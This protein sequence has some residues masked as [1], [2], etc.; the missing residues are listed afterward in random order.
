VNESER[1]ETWMAIV[2]IMGRM[3]EQL[4][5]SKI[6]LPRPLH[7]PSDE[8]AGYAYNP[9]CDCDVCIYERETIR[10]AQSDYPDY[11]KRA[12]DEQ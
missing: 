7:R 5:K 8:R 10:K 2:Y 12:V 3:S 9:A 1:I 6:D 4:V 11:L